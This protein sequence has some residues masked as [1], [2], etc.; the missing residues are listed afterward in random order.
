M[1]MWLVQAFYA[2]PGRTWQ[3]INDYP[4]REAADAAINNHRIQDACY[5]VELW[6]HAGCF[7]AVG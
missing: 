2:T 1:M 3:E 4:T 5:L 7:H 6:Q